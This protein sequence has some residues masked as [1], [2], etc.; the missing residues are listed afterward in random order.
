MSAT[1]L[2]WLPKGLNIGMELIYEDT[3][4]PIVKPATIHLVLSLAVSR[5]SEIAFKDHGDL[6][7][8]LGIEVL[9][10]LKAFF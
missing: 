8:F 4:S 2:D 9:R 5:G 7:Y 10:H 3:F 1:R 6:H